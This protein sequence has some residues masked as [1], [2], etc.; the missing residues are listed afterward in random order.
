[1]IRVFDV[2]RI[3][4]SGD[5]SVEALGHI[6]LSVES[7]EA[8]AL[9]GPSGSGKTSLLNLI[10]GLDHPTS[11]EVWVGGLRVDNLGESALTAFRAKTLGLVFQDPFLLPGLTALEN[12]A[13]AR[14]PWEPRRELESRG[15]ELLASVGLKDRMHHP[16]GRLSAGE[17]QRVGLAR[18]LLGSPTLLIADEPTGNLDASTTHGIL[19][20]LQ[21]IRQKTG[22]TVVIATHDAAVAS[23]ADRII[24][25]AG[26][27]LEPPGRDDAQAAD[28]ARTS[29]QTSHGDGPD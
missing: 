4:Q 6:T 13:I 17:R 25:L 15:R 14:L 26:G 2:T 29:Q 21:G 24:T 16:P 11:G 19:K 5:S 28:L 18:A 27:R 12:V 23:V 20:L 22:V 7:G 10:A 9:M 1:V 3:F 8:I